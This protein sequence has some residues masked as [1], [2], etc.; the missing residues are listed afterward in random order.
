MRAQPLEAG[1]GEDGGE[2]SA[3]SGAEL[4]IR[5]VHA[6][7]LDG[8]RL[9][10]TVGACVTSLVRLMSDSLCDRESAA[11]LSIEGGGRCAVDRPATRN[12]QAFRPPRTARRRTGSFAH[13]ERRAEEK[14]RHRRWALVR[15]VVSG[16]QTR[17]RDL[18][19]RVDGAIP[20]QGSQSDFSATD[21]VAIECAG[22]SARINLQ[23]GLSRQKRSKHRSSDTERINGISYDSA[24]A[25]QLGTNNDF[26]VR[27]RDALDVG[28]ARSQDG[29]L[30]LR[31]LFC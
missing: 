31:H 17:L 1:S 23:K 9:D 27:A 12:R 24:A 8:L 10:A 29:K 3:A 21:Q 2:N 14:R 26:D 30:F 11:S 20:S 13:A 19:Q 6:S 18:P 4:I 5:G 15:L 28:V 22:D 25:I 16:C 7:C